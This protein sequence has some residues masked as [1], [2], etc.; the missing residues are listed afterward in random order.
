MKSSEI[1]FSFESGASH[2]KV[3]AAWLFLLYS[4]SRFSSSKESNYQS[5]KNGYDESFKWAI[6]R[7][8][9]PVEK[10]S[11]SIDIKLRATSQTLNWEG[12]IFPVNLSNINKF[13]NHNSSISVNVFG[14]ENPIYP[15]RISKHNC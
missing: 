1:S 12:L 4:A 9:N 3:Y 8:L 14:Y 5:E 2:R 11:E 15:L 6:T 13:E 10:N 7:A